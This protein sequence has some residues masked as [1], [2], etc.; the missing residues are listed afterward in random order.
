MDF[1]ST[2]V[3]FFSISPL[4]ALL[5]LS[6]P[7]L[8][9]LHLYSMF[10]TEDVILLL[11][12]PPTPAFIFT[13]L[14]FL[15]SSISRPPPSISPC[16]L[17]VFPQLSIPH[18]AS[19]SCI[20]VLLSCIFNAFMFK[21]RLLMVI[22]N[23]QIIHF[24]HPLYAYCLS[25]QYNNYL[26]TPHLVLPHIQTMCVF[27]AF[28][29]WT[30]GF[31]CVIHWGWWWSVTHHYSLPCL[32]SYGEL[33]TQEKTDPSCLPLLLVRLGHYSCWQWIEWHF[34][35]LQIPT[36]ET[37]LAHATAWQF[38]PNSFNLHLVWTRC[39]CDWL[40]YMPSYLKFHTAW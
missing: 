38:C 13:P 15:W 29:L 11:N 20:M 16:S 21:K 37:S 2:Q 22:L 18:P 17:H 28:Q 32:F 25:L 4:S 35:A 31:F 7:P 40:S 10:P 9:N 34:N 23:A 1:L 26:G 5:P 14:L 27:E 39:D 12:H 30:Y 3:I 36:V 33:I 24:V 6:N 8:L 19:L